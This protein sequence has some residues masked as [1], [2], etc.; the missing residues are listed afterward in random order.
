MCKTKQKT[1]KNWRATEVVT[2]EI[3]PKHTFRVRV[4]GKNFFSKLKLLIFDF[5]RDEIA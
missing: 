3:L 2:D 5:P 1:K 4:I